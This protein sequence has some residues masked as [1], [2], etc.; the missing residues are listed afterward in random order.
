MRCVIRLVVVLAGVLGLWLLAP[1]CGPSAGFAVVFGDELIDDVNF[2]LV[3]YDGAR[4]GE[5]I[6]YQGYWH[7]HGIGTPY[8]YYDPYNP[9]DPYWWY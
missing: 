7:Y 1:S 2:G 4:R 6:F 5:Y 8:Y 3:L 9:Y